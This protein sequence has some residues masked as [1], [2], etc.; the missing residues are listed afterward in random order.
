MHQKSKSALL[1]SEL[2]FRVIIPSAIVINLYAALQNFGNH[3]AP[4]T[5]T[6]SPF[7]DFGAHAQI[8]LI[9]RP[10]GFSR[11]WPPN[12]QDIA[13][14]VSWRPISQIELF[15]VA[16]CG[17]CEAKYTWETFR[18]E[19]PII[20]VEFQMS[21]APGVMKSRNIEIVICDIRKSRQSITCTSPAV[22]RDGRACCSISRV[23]ASL[24][25]RRSV[26]VCGPCSCRA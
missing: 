19:F 12:S 18:M 2:R 20:C 17:L 11:H 1:L 4:G 13:G 16:A 5:A 10:R 7:V 6:T 24:G 25:S 9:H 23:R 14:I 26:R 8:R 21:T 3:D 15:A 22:F